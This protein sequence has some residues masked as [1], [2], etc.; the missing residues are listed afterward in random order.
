MLPRKNMNNYKFS[1][2]EICYKIR[3]KEVFKHIVF[4]C[5]EEKLNKTK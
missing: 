1:T 5:V 3:E 4:D 2:Y